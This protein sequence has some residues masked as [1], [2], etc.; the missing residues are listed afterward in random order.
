[1]VKMT[2]RERKIYKQKMKE[3]KQALKEGNE[4]KADRLANELKLQFGMR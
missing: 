4:E 3:I 1:M 2:D